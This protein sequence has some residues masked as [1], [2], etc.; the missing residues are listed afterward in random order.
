MPL[1]SFALDHDFRRVI[2]KSVYFLAIVAVVLNE[3]LHGRVVEPLLLRDFVLGQLENGEIV[4]DV[5]A[6][7]LGEAMTAIQT[8]CMG[9]CI[10]SYS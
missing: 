4:N 6:V 2:E 10:L 1:P 9:L 3:R 7:A 5:D 8:A